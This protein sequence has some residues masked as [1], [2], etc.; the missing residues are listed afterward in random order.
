MFSGEIVQFG[1][2]AF[3]PT[4]E[5]DLDCVMRMEA[6]PENVS[7]IRQWPI[8]QH[9]AAILDENVAHLIV[10]ST[11]D[12]KIIGYIILVGLENPDRSIEFKRIVIKE[13]NKRFGTE[14]LHLVK[15]IAFENLGAHRLWLEVMEHNE[16]AIQLYE[17]AGFVS[18]GLHRESLKQGEHFLS[19]KV[20]SILAHEYSHQ[21]DRHML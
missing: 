2:I 11:S 12:S 9:Q 17:S 4:T 5:I 10:Q 21:V 15:R 1:R 14:S 20:M 16:R 6:A 7:F 8:Q 18:E 13:K 19:L 3:R